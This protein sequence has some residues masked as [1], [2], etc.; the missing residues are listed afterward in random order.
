RRCL[1]IA[2]GFYEWRRDGKAKTPHLIRLRSNEPFALAGIWTFDRS[3]PDKIPTCAIL[4]CG[5]NELMARIHDRMPVILSPQAQQRWLDRITHPGELCDLLM[6]YPAV[7]MDAYAVSPA[8]N[9]AARDL[10]TCIAPA[11][12]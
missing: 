3:S 1:V 12:G 6:P 7:E 11:E 5:P 10:P 8:V 2:D 4:T 9:S